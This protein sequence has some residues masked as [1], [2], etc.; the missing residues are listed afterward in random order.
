MD[1]AATLCP[2]DFAQYTIQEHIL[3]ATH[4]I[5]AQ[6]SVPTHDP[7]H[8]AHDA[9][10]KSFARVLYRNNRSAHDATARL[11]SRTPLAVH[12]RC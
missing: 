6:L 12:V 1:Q 7:I 5:S 3:H 9:I 2:M 4:T 11:K 8:P 10:Q